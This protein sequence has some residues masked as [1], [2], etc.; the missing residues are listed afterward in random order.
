M[1]VTIYHNP[2]CSKSRE[3][4]S[5]LEQHDVHPEVILYLDDPPTAR[6]LR[7]VLDLLEISA[8]DLLR[9]GEEP[10]QTLALA[11]PS[12]TDEVLIQAM[13]DNPILIQRPIVVSGNRALIGRPPD[14]VL[15]IL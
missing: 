5:L 2:H 14:R 4:L 12:L 15:E 1:A 3:A 6:E 7:E 8:R 10:F 13:V 11:D 9:T